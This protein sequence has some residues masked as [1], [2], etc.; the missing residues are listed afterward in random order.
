MITLP[1]PRPPSAILYPSTL[2]YGTGLIDIPVAWVSPNS[3]ESV[4]HGL[5]EDRVLLRHAVHHQLRRQAQH[6]LL[7]RHALEA[8]LLRRPVGVQPESELRILRP[9]ARAQAAASKG[10]AVDRRRI[11]KSRTLYAR[12]AIPRRQRHLRLA[13]RRHHRHRPVVRETLPQH[14]DHVRRGDARIAAGA[15]G[16]ASVSLGY[17]S[18]IFHDDGGLGRNYNDKG[19]IVKGLF[20]GARYAMR[21]SQNSNV[22]VLAENNGWDWNAGVVGNWR[23]LSLGVY[24]T[25]LEEGGKDPSKGSLYTDLQLHEVQRLARLQ[26]QPARHRARNHSARAHRRARAGAASSSR[27]DRAAAAQ[28]RGVCRPRCRRRRAASSPKWRSAASSS[29]RRSRKSR[30]P[31]SAPKSV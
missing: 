25:E 5:R 8:A 16:A 28:D 21:T 30:K 29:T 13:H 6:E 11:Q 9:G 24:G 20:L 3:G 22:T 10:V 1:S 23:G 18:G 2:D 12:G 27:A 7:D 15:K 4:G 26:R 19:T 31:S 14:A 17:G